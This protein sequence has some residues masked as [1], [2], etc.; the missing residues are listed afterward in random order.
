[1]IKINDGHFSTQNHCLEMPYCCK[2]QHFVTISTVTRSSLQ[3]HLCIQVSCSLHSHMQSHS[4]RTQCPLEKSRKYQENGFPLDQLFSFVKR[5]QCLAGSLHICQQETEEQIAMK[6][7]TTWS[8]SEKTFFHVAEPDMN[9]VIGRVLWEVKN[10]SLCSHKCCTK[11][12]MR[13]TI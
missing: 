13:G 8:C 6:F 9:M 4:S 3:D 10:A 11:L 5:I 7:K 12:R 2:M 1:M